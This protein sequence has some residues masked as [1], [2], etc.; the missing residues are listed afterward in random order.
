MKKHNKIVVIQ[1]DAIQTLNSKTDT[2]LLLALEAQRRGYKIYYYE[3][4]NLTFSKG[5]IYAL[6]KEIK[7]FENNKNFYFIKRLKKI[8]LCTFNLSTVFIDPP[9][10]GL[11][12]STLKGLNRFKQIIYVSCGFESLKKDIEYLSETH[13]IEAAG[14]FD[15]FPYTDHIESAVVLKNK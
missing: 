5:I 3:T 12:T 1:G 6:S 7:F 9:R 2:T 14:F 13:K 11:D 10:S 4:H 8:D 15:Q